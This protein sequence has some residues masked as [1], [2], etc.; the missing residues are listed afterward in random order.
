MIFA[1]DSVTSGAT[2]ES[3][4]ARAGLLGARR[5]RGLRIFKRHLGV[6]GMQMIPLQGLFHTGLIGRSMSKRWLGFGLHSCVPNCLIISRQAVQGR[7]H[8]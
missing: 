4:N 3:C 5:C 7:F 1:G 8:Y 6:P 2:A